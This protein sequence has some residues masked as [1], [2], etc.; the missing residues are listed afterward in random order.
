MET[1]GELR[2]KRVLLRVDFNVPL[3]DDSPP[4]VADDYRLTQA[5]PTIQLLKEQGA[6]LVLCS[7]F[8]RP[9]GK[10]PR[11]SL[12]P[13]ASKLGG[14]LGDPVAFVEETVG[15]TAERAVE[16]LQPGELLLLENLR[17]DPREERGSPELAQ[18]LA[19]LADIYVNDAF[20]AAHRAH[21]SITG[22]AELLPSAAG[23]LMRREVEALTPLRDGSAVRP[24]VAV[25]GGAKV[26]DKLPVLEAL[27]DKVDC[28]LVG[29]AM[30]YTFLHA[31]DNS[32][33]ASLLD[34]GAV[35]RA[36]DLLERHSNKL[37]L[38]RDHVVSGR[39]RD[40]GG[41]AIVD[42]IPEGRMGLDIGPQTIADYCRRLR[43]ARTVFWNGPLGLFERRPFHLITQYVAT[44]LSHTPTIHAVVGGGDSAAATRELGLEAGMA[45]ISTGGG[46]SLEYV[47]GH[48]LPGLDALGA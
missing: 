40:L 37:E 39:T 43:D 26:A 23:E 27:F 4:T 46:A 32:I 13:V 18:A 16:S 11:L 35:N 15:P 1:L 44:V 42:E 33:G 24:Y 20:G 45:W 7:H 14:L 2:G 8:G 12:A 25:I 6:R 22:V 30:A 21:A 9:K 38:P 41:F 34:E 19:G 29:G 48:V 10:D 3:T 31:R 5:L 17:F 36:R 47:Q 28:V